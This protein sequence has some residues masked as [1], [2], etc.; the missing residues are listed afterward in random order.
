MLLPIKPGAFLTNTLFAAS[1]LVDLCFCSSA[2]AV[3]VYSN[4]F[5]VNAAGFTS[6]STTSFASLPTDAL[7]FSSPNQSRYLG[8]YANDS[9]A[10]TL[11][12]LVPGT[13]YS[14]AFDLFI[15][16][17]W[18]GNSTSAGP[19]TWSLT[20]GFP[21]A[22]TL[23]STT[24]SN[25][26]SSD[27]PMSPLCV[28]LL[29]QKAQFNAQISAVEQAVSQTLTGA[30][31]AAA[32]AQLQAVRAQGN[33]Q[34]DAALALAGC[35]MP[36][37]FF[38][39]SYSDLTPVGPGAFP[40]FTGADVAQPTGGILDRYAIYSFG[41]GAGNPP[42]S[43]TALGNSEILTFSGQNLE[44]VTNEFWAIDNLVVSTEAPATTVPES[45]E[46]LAW[47][48]LTGVLLLSRIWKSE[49]L[50]QAA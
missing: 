17:S 11:T 49:P 35:P 26:F 37:N 33:A 27:I 8:R 44:G 39:Q 16:A 5:E 40:A 14:V 41:H 38:T 22:G 12:G 45:S 19:D 10:L 21:A 31:L 46:G 30:A 28:T 42:L 36:N 13:T 48:A 6:S 18:D 3:A 34:L 4:D 24:F 20:T 47:F 32:L 23:I 7:G 43:F 1:S 9:L 15:G 29:T 25:L 50:R 2:H